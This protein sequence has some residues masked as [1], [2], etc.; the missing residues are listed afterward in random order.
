MEVR[1]F[2]RDS[3]RMADECVTASED[4]TATALGFGD[5]KRYRSA[6][7]ARKSG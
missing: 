7:E 2:L 6:H 5:R 3:A 4:K 1:F